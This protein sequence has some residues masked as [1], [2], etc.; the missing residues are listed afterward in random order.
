VS[1]RTL[2][3]LLSGLLAALLTGAAAAAPVPYV[4]YLPGP[5]FDTLGE[6]DGTPVISV[7]GRETFPTEGHLDLTT[8]SVRPR[9]TLA[10]A[11]RDWFDRDR[12]VVPRELLYPPG[13][14]D[15]EVRRQNEERRLASESS[16]TSAALRQLGIPFTT[17][18]EVQRVEPGLPAD[19]LLRPGDVVTSVEGSPVQSSAQLRE[20]V[21]G[22]EPGSSVRVGYLREGAAAEVALTTAAPPAGE[23]RSV[24]GIVLAEKPD[25]PF[26][27]TIS[28][29]EVGGPSAGLMFALG[30]IEKLQAE[31][32][33][34]G[35][36]V[37]GTGEISVDGAVG[38]IGGIPQK[39][40]AARDK[41]AEVFLVPDANCEEALGRAPDG[42]QL[43][44]VASL[45]GAL[46][47]LRTLR[48]GGTPPLCRS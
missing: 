17:A 26:E 18:V 14:T 32:L 46:D 31:S 16:A 1:R 22:L 12:A 3:L 28:L 2:T 19:G 35:R 21:S 34:G 42:L 11:L 37:A 30:I 43:V 10:E 41:G 45:Q 4:A 36:Y 8:I 47:A 15:E 23:A 7:E 24:V 6:V 44:R 40:V 29:E 20:R 33:T 27:I 5:T 38:A 39:L 25:Y 13:E 48:E 9:L